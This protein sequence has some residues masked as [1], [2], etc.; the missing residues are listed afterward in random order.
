MRLSLRDGSAAHKEDSKARRGEDREEIHTKE[1]DSEG[2]AQI[3]ER[4]VETGHKDNEEE[5]SHPE[6]GPEERPPI[7]RLN[8]HEIMTIDDY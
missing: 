4:E 2:R 3:G 8:D 7:A 1:S 6:G 5:R